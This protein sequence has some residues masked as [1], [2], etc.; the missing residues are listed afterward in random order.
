[1]EDVMNNNDLR[2]IIF[3]FFRKK[4]HKQC[5]EC[6]RVLMWNENKTLHKFVEWDNFL[7]CNDCFKFNFF[8]HIYNDY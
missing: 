8:K 1:M 3:S 7:L 6:K 4:P 2:Y 5:T